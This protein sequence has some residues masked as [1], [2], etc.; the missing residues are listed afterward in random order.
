MD[1]PRLPFT[2]RER[3]L[4]A[5]LDTPEK[6][7]HWLSAMPYNWERQ[8]ET[9]RTFRGVVRA[10][11]AHC[12]EA[13]LSA[14]CILEQRGFPPL[15][16]DIE[17]VD[18]LD[19]VL[20]VFRRRGKWGAVG[21]SRCHGLHGRKPVFR[22]LRAL[23]RSYSAPFIDTTGRV[24]G[25]GV[26]DLRDLPTGQWRLAKGDV[27]HIE[28]ALTDN[29]HHRLPTPAREYHKWKTRYDA[30]WRAHGRPA[31]DWPVFAD[32]PYRSTWMR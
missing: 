19:H 15:L 25:Y 16:M 29:R 11:T 22:S 30:W 3:A 14:A 21:R 23:A 32:Y 27:F 17:S 2:P 26:L 1:V 10:G 13:A 9:A 31:H 6:V 12:L 8:G 7:Q 4:V 24:K 20:F 18:L 28:R 5:R